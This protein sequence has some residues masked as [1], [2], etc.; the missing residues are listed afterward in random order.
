MRA[1]TR[2]TF[3]SPAT[4]WREERVRVGYL[5]LDSRIVQCKYE[6]GSAAWTSSFHTRRQ[7]ESRYFGDLRAMGK[8]DCYVLEEIQP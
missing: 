7:A 3:T 8:N 4:K 6:D 2:W 1:A 5:V